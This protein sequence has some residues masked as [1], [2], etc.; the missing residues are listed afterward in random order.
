MGDRADDGEG[1]V[2]HSSEGDPKTT[3][4]STE[5][6]DYGCVQEGSHDARLGA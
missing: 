4:R 3:I 2:E 1:S 6:R 5:W